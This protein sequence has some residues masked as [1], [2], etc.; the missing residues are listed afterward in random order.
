MITN[1]NLTIGVAIVV[2]IVGA[3]IVL[4]QSRHEGKNPAKT[5]RK[6][7]EV[8]MS[9]LANLSGCALPADSDTSAGKYDSLAKCLT[10]KGVK[11]YGA[12]WCPHCQNQKKAFGDS[13]KYINYTE[14]ADPNV[15][16]QLEVCQKAKIES[17]P[18][19][20]VPAKEQ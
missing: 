7:G 8:A 3:A 17:Y 2:L 6:T 11:M 20:E 16:G 18:T 1:K 9:E 13:F 4:A 12:Y 14:C 19:W 10:D 15:E 5:F